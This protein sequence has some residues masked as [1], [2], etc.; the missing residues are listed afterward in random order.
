MALR[1]RQ[2]IFLAQLRNVVTAAVSVVRTIFVATVAPAF[3]KSL[4]TIEEHEPVSD[5]RFFFH[6]AEHSSDLEQR[7][8]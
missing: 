1:I 4:F 7:C 3:T 6:T 8:H 5:F 2:F